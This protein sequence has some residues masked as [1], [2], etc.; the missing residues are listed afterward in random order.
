M[1]HIKGLKALTIAAA[2]LLGGEPPLEDAQPVLR[3]CPDERPST[4]RMVTQFLSSPVDDWT[5]RE[6]GL[7][8]VSADEVRLLTDPSDAAACL[9]L[10]PSGP[11]GGSMGWHWT[12]YTAGGRYFVALQEV[13]PLGSPGRRF[14]SAPLLVYDAEFKRIAAY[15]M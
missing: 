14:K 4:R 10:H 12:F 5:R 11:V 3:A 9:A 15:S 1:K 6:T 13:H 2:L 8:K 7:V